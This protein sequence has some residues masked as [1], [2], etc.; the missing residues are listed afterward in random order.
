MMTVNLNI[1]EDVKKI[2]TS[3][4][5]A[6]YIL[7]TTTGAGE[8][9]D[10]EKAKKDA[11]IMAKLKS[12]KKL[13]EK[14]LAYLKKT[15]PIMYAHAM[16]VQLMVK[17]VEEQL[18][19]AKSKEEA[20]RI[21]A[22]AVGGIAKDDPDREYLVAALNRI[23]MEMHKSSGY[24]RLPNTDA[25]VQ[26]RREQKA[27]IEFEDAEEEEDEDKKGFDLMNWSPLQEVIDAL[28]KFEAGV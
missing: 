6:K 12:G 22:S 8:L 5:L 17:G 19:H 27:G 3:D 25:D 9:S 15:N 10:E 13:T 14:E 7:D 20:N 21:V 26:K 24:N 28:P 4:E 18:K 1:K 2:T 16:R 23:S 11:Q